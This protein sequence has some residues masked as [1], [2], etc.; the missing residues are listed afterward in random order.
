M[1]F[2]LHG[3]NKPELFFPRS[4]DGCM[5]S[6][7]SQSSS[8]GW[9]GG[10]LCMPKS[11]GV[12]TMPCPKYVCQR[13]LTITRAVVGD[14]LSTSHLAK[15]RRDGTRESSSAGLSADGEVDTWRIGVPRSDS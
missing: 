13:R 2:R 10:S 9:E 3:C 15:L 1:C 6:Q 4:T 12:L 7:A 14:F 8:S 11:S 5:N